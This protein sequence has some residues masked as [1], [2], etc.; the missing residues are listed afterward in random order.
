MN[1][2]RYMRKLNRLLA[3]E[4][5][6]PVYRWIYSESPEFQRAMRVVDE[7][8]KPE[9][10]YRCVCGLNATIHRAT[11]TLVSA[12]PKWTWRK[13]IPDAIDQ[14]VLCCHQAPPTEEEWQNL[15]GSRLMYP[16][17]GSW[18]PVGTET[19]Q[20]AMRPGELPGENFNL[21]IIRGRQRSREIHPSEIVNA[22]EYAEAR[23]DQ[24]RRP[25]LRHRLTDAL[26]LNPDPGKRNAGV[27]WGGVGE[28][29][30]LNLNSNS[31]EV[32]L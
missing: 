7:F 14:W 18:A 15:F 26:T 19:R 31:R 23:R 32:S 20:I 25:E 10:D 3:S 11:C 1:V 29:P 17:G 6:E 28:S 8:L 24:A 9:W 16:A 30:V 21:A 5:G 27:S 4:L 22:Y 12:V 2:E 13:T